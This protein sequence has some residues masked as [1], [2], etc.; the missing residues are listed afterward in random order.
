MKFDKREGEVLRLDYN[1]RALVTIHQNGICVSFQASAALAEAQRTGLAVMHEIIDHAV[2]K[3]GD[4]RVQRVM[5]DA[6]AIGAWLLPDE[7]D[8]VPEELSGYVLEAIESAAREA[9]ESLA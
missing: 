8:K 3:S 4:K 2:K 6:M 7:W 9:V 5:E 1:A